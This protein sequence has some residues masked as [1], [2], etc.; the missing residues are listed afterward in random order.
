MRA[1]NFENIEI[2]NTVLT[3]YLDEANER[4]FMTLTVRDIDKEERCV[5]TNLN[6]GMDLYPNED[7]QYIV[8]DE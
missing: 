7:D 1:V 8:I 3:D 4:T 6:G 2:G 5:E